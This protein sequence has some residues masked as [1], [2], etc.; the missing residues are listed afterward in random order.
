MTFWPTSKSRPRTRYILE[1]E[2]HRYFLYLK[3]SC[4]I[5]LETRDGINVEVFRK[6][7]DNVPKKCA[8]ATAVKGGQTKVIKVN[9]CR[10]GMTGFIY[11]YPHKVILQEK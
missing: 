5:E 7:P 11:I 10:I 1:N 9:N 4:R 6:Y 2:L 3:E 8:A